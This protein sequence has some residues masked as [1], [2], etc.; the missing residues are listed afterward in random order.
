MT[1]PDID[2]REGVKNLWQNR[3]VRTEAEQAAKQCQN[4]ALKPEFFDPGGRLLL[5]LFLKVVI[6]LK[7]FCNEKQ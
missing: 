6:N 7:A 4:N 1:N 2:L 3:Q 5:F